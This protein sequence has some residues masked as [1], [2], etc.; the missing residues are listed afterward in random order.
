MRDAYDRQVR[1]WRGQQKPKISDH[2]IAAKNKA[3]FWQTS[4]SAYDGKYPTYS[5]SVCF[6]EWWPIYQDLSSSL[7]ILIEINHHSP[8]I[9]VFDNDHD[10]IG[11]L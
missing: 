2:N 6:L 8:G 1:M 5:F 10:A 4:V 11:G 9:Q 3:S 7:A